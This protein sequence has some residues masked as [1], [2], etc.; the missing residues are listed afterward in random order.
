MVLRIAQILRKY[1]QR[2]EASE[3]PSAF[4]GEKLAGL[5]HYDFVKLELKIRETIVAA[6][7]SRH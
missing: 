2:Y 1:F 4:P 3:T 5:T 6:R 7:K